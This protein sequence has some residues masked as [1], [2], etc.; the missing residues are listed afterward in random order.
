MNP[1]QIMVTKGR[2]DWRPSASKI[3]IGKQIA[4]LVTPNKTDKRKPPNWADS[5]EGN[6]RGSRLSTTN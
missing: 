5:T 1:T 2:F 6:V 4:I 3:P